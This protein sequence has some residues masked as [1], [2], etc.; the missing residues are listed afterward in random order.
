MSGFKY[1][2]AVGLLFILACGP[3]VEIG[4]GGPGGS[5]GSG[6]AGS[7]AAG[8]PDGAGGD[9]GVGGTIGT[10]GT[11]ATAPT[12]GTTLGGSGV[13][14][15]IPTDNGPQAEV[16]KVDLLLAIDNSISM[17]DKQKLFAKAVPELV[18][19]LINPRCVSTTGVVVEEPASP[20]DACPAGS[21]REFEALRDLHVGLITSSLGSHGA[22]DAKDVCVQADDDDHAHLLHSLRN[23]PSYNDEGYMNWDPD[24]KSKPAGDSD[25]QAFA[26]ALSVAIAAAGEHGC[27]YEAQ[28][29]SIYRFLV[30]PEP[31][32]QIQ[33][34]GSITQRT[35]I[36]Q[37][38]LE[39]RKNFLRPDSSVVVLM[40][41]DE[42]DCS[43]VDEGYGWLI[44]RAASMY[45]STSQCA[46][47]PNDP[48]CQSCV[49]QSPNPGCPA[50][51]SD[52]ACAKGTTL[53]MDS[54][55]LN[56]RCWQQKRRFGFDL[57]YPLQ[58]YVSGFG[59]GVVPDNNGK[60]V[61][62]PLFHS[63]GK[64]R[65]PSLFTLAVLGGVPWQD[66]ATS[67]S[68]K[69]GSLEY[70]TNAQLTTAKRW[71]VFLGDPEN[72]VPPSDPFMVEQP[73]PRTGQNPI[74]GDKIV[75]ETSMAPGA[76]AINGHEQV[77]VGNSD[78]QYACTFQ[79][80]EPRVCDAA[81]DMAGGGCDCFNEDALFNRSICQPPAGG[82][83]GTTQYQ[84][85]AYPTLREFAVAQQ[86]GRRSV[87]GS[88]C[89]VNT[90]DDTRG[91]YGYRPIFNAIGKRVADTLIKP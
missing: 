65:D 30:D 14:G 43:I 23:L 77:N 8:A 74:T 53:P 25:P 58:R 71:S 73:D 35:G 11:G 31:P 64:R 51:T 91:D 57:L 61:A 27:G 16:D 84:G 9:D 62:N 21:K 29:E 80:P 55:N 63:G 69:G 85:K 78:L 83:S 82:N 75:G 76:N 89:A 6:Q 33:L 19:R 86:L 56:L 48:C 66:L 54:D 40:L 79:L 41:T 4:H 81:L 88:V 67:A 45:R 68:L 46:A 36:D 34:V 60:P 3:K 2:G 18:K 52:P 12:A 22:N 87:L 24:G 50:L 7:G 59:D 13:G 39:Q 32:A 38:V 37:T 47:D 1:A 28:L 70:M 20:D 10:A 5:A 49:E 44:P 15:P 26:D 90:Q 72:Y 42:N 17:A